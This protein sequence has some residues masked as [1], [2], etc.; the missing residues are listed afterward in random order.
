MATTSAVDETTGGN[1]SVAVIAGA[2]PSA[3][4]VRPASP[5]VTM[6]GQSTSTT[7]VTSTT[8]MTSFTSTQR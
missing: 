3:S 6:P 4:A 5:A 2:A 8:L 7:R 1:T